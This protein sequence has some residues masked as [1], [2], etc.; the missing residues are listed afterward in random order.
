MI[1]LNAGRQIEL[2]IIAQIIEAEFIVST[3]SD[4]GG[5]G[6]LTLEIVHV[7]LNAANFQTEKAIDLA[8]PFGVA[9]SQVIIHRD[10]VH[11]AAGQRV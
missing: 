8:H 3:V 1:A 11:A 4:V 5:V 9:R 7:V 6:C 10:N 2:H